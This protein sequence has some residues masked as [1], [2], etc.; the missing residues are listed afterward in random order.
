MS[1]GEHL[2]PFEYRRIQT[3]AAQGISPGEIPSIVGR[4]KATVWRVLNG[5]SR[6]QRC[7]SKK[8]IIYGVRPLE[9]KKALS[10][11]TGIGSDCLKQEAD[12]LT[13]ELIQSNFVEPL[14]VHFAVR[15]LS[16]E[17]FLADLV[18][19]FM[20][21]DF[22]IEVLQ[23]AARSFIKTRTATKFPPVA[24]CIAMCHEAQNELG[25]RQRQNL[26]GTGVPTSG[27]DHA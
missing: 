15:R 6:P 19:A 21:E 24:V 5:R 18:A 1:K 8:Q 9:T 12:M 26:E 4:S 2:T 22:S 3:L 10:L 20:E 27:A 23:R 17:Y 16:S 25:P 13:A 7:A 14:K 11:E